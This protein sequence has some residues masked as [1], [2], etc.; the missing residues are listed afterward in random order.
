MTTAVIGLGRI[1]KEVARHLVAGGESV[2][3]ATRQQA[4]AETLARQLGPLARVA[5]VADAIA[6]ADA[7]VLAVWFDTMKELIVTYREQLQGKVV[8]DTSNPVRFT[9]TGLA[10]TLPDGVSSGSVIAE[11]LPDGAHFAKAFGTMNAQSLADDANRSPNRAVL[12]YATDDQIAEQ[13]AERLIRI[14]GF[15]PVKAGGIVPAALR[16]EVFGDLAQFGGLN[17]QVLDRVQALAR[18]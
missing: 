12:F 7:I 6:D 16:I 5:S 14:A 9:D 17:G 2:V 8:F 18:L 11:L 10:R 1:G 15:E 13:S 4:D 3:L